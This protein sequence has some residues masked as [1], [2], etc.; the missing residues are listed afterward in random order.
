MKLDS[1]NNNYIPEASYSAIT[2][3]CWMLDEEGKTDNAKMGSS[4]VQPV[5]E[6]AKRSCW[7][8]DEPP[9]HEK[10]PANSAPNSLSAGNFSQV[11]N[12]D[13]F[14]CLAGALARN[15][16][17]SP[18]AKPKNSKIWTLALDSTLVVCDEQLVDSIC[19]LKQ[20]DRS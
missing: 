1:A 18:Q 10:N 17:T 16:V 5:S 3:G 8:L 4:S 9:G 19:I 20:I 13:F 11:Q 6:L 14:V 7:M 12:L 15:I 2:G